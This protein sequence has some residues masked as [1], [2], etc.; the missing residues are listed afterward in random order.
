MPL[1]SPI[2]TS[3]PLVDARYGTQDYVPSHF[4]VVTYRDGGR[5]ITCDPRQASGSVSPLRP[6]FQNPQ[7]AAARRQLRRRRNAA[8]LPQR[9][10]AELGGPPGSAA[11]SDIVVPAGCAARRKSWAFAPI[12]RPPRPRDTGGRKFLFRGVTL[13]RLLTLS[14]SVLGRRS[15]LMLSG[16]RHH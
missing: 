9:H 10:R 14:G 8:Q 2:A 3:V 7:E 12:S 11:A 15:A 5:T 13:P 1:T 4:V 16:C 6:Q